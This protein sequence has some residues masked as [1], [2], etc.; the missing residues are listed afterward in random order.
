MGH[1]LRVVTGSQSV[2]QGSGHGVW[3]PGM[4]SE[5]QSVEQGLRVHWITLWAEV[6]QEKQ[7]QPAQPPLMTP[8]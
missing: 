1:D 2:G 3:V 4:W 6:H 5:F 8:C 7:V